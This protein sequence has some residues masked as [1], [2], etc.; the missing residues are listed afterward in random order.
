LLLDFWRD[1]Q[2]DFRSP[3][4]FVDLAVASVARERAGGKVLT[5]NRAFREIP[6]IK[7]EPA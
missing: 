7:V 2:T 4:N 3:L 6:G 5:F 1:F